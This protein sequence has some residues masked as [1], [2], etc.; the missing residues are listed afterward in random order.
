MVVLLRWPVECSERWDG[1]QAMENQRRQSGLGLEWSVN[2]RDTRLQSNFE[3]E[4]VILEA[5]LME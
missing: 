4:T 5:R 3:T 2:E 1:K